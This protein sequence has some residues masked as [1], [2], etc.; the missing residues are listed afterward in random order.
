MCTLV[1]TN[2]YV[3]VESNLI[4]KMNIHQRKYFL[5]YFPPKKHKKGKLSFQAYSY[6]PLA[7]QTLIKTGEN[8]NLTRRHLCCVNL[9][10]AL[11]II[12]FS[13]NDNV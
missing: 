10:R 2:L 5:S 1:E 11:I 12:L 6:S 3:G 4:I 7:Q 9:H 13:Y 8:V